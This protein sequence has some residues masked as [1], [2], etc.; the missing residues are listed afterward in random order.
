M[1]SQKYN[2]K[3]I[4]AEAKIKKELHAQI[5]TLLMNLANNCAKLNSIVFNDPKAEGTKFKMVLPFPPTVYEIY[6]NYVKNKE[7]TTT[8][9]K[10]V[11]GSQQDLEVLLDN[12]KIERLMFD[13]FESDTTETGLYD[14]YRLFCFK[15]LKRIGLLL[16][17]NT[18]SPERIDRI[19]KKMKEFMEVIFPI[20]EDKRP[21]NQPFLELASELLYSQLES[22]RSF[23]IKD[24]KKNIL[25]IFDGNDFFK[26]TKQTLKYWSKIIDWVIT[27]DRTDLFSEFLAKVS[28]FSFFFSKDT[29]TKQKIKAFERICFIIY[30]GERD[31]YH[32]KLVMLL[33]KMAEVI[34]NAES[35]HPSLLILILFCVRILILRLSPSTLNDLFRHIWPILLTLLM[36]IFNKKNTQNYP[37]LILAALKL[38]E[39][40]TVIQLEEFYIN[41]WV[42]LFDYFGLTLEPTYS[43]SNPPPSDYD[44]TNNKVSGFIY[45][46]YVT[47]CIQ[48]NLKINYKTKQIDVQKDCK[49]MDR[50]IVMTMTN[51]DDEVEIKA[52][53]LFLCQYLIQQNE[54]RTQVDPQQIE[55]L[56][57]GDFISLDDYIFKIN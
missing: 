46:P 19:I 40:M 38:I 22:S 31:K 25:D 21:E 6:K 54:F 2:P 33:E 29:E 9:I 42:F 15:T 18:Y 39:L 55:S 24:Y 10:L 4:L 41:Q 23:L 30:S 28:A 53:A 57:E 26:C 43:N 13:K 14:R 50:K 1:L 3:E 34:K 20:M 35:S 11:D 51:V 32:N 12:I 7:A 8:Q 27:M 47:N 52:K 56:I 37:N 44:A 17:Q 49:K 5:T 36:Q 48:D 16:V 45:Q